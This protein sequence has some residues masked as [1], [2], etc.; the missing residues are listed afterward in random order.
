[1]FVATRGR[2]AVRPHRRENTI[3]ITGLILFAFGHGLG[4]AD[5]HAEFGVV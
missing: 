1:M 4:G 5:R 3:L 2:Q